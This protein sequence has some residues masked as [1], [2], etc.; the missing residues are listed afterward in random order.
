MAAH[1]ARD[2]AR[3]A[4][5]HAA[6]IRVSVRQLATTWLIWP[7][8]EVSRAVTASMQSATC[9]GAGRGE[10][11]GGEARDEDQGGRA[12]A[13][14][15]GADSDAVGDE[16][17]DGDEVQAVVRRFVVRAGMHGVAARVQQLRQAHQAAEQR[18]HSPLAFARLGF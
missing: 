17:P 12:D 8:A 6:S 2:T 14:V 13:Q 7:S 3:T 16:V 18:I 10:R 11:G 1:A 9:G 15:L 4:S 5:G